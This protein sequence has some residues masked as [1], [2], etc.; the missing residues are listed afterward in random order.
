M[1]ILYLKSGLS[2]KWMCFDI[3]SEDGQNQDLKGFHPNESFWMVPGTVGID[4]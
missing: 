1:F 4:D 2:G 3:W